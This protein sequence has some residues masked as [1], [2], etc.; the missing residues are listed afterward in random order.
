[1]LFVSIKIIRKRKEVE[2]EGLEKYDKMYGTFFDGFCGK[3]QI[4]F[5]FYLV[6]FLRRILLS[7]TIFFVAVP[8]YRLILSLILSLSVSFRQNLSFLIETRCFKSKIDNI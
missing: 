4:N 2:S 5:W 3:D 6:F 8:I 1:M 7:L